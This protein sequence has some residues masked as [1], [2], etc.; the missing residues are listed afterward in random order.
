MSVFIDN[1][2][3]GTTTNEEGNYA[4][5]IT[6]PGDYTVVFQYLGYKTLRKKI[7][8]DRFPFLLNTTLVEEDIS[9]Q[10]VVINSEENP[11]IQIIRHAIAKR[12]EHLEK[13]ETYLANFYSRGLIKIK[14]AP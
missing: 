2:Y 12:V 4:L 10:E 11:A 1:T 8:I 6:K 5:D 14:D 3:I 9:L 7:T 13:T